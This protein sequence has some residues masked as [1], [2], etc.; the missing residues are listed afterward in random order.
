MGKSEESSSVKVSD[1]VINKT[2]AIE[3]DKLWGVYD[4]LTGFIHFYKVMQ[5][6]RKA[7]CLSATDFAMYC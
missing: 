6:Y 2:V 7:A 1:S 4:S 3:K 5:Y